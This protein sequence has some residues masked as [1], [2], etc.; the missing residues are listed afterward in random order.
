MAT[1]QILNDDSSKN[2][3]KKYIIQNSKNTFK[4]TIM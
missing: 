3:L 1:F 2:E 4:Y